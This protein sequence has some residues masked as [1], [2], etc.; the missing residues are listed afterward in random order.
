MINDSHDLALF[1]RVHQ[2]SAQFRRLF[3]T[4]LGGR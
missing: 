3:I 2:V 4:Y 1:V